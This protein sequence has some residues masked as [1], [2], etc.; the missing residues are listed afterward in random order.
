MNYNV[1][2]GSA[3]IE[4]AFI[5]PFYYIGNFF[6]KGIDTAFDKKLEKYRNRVTRATTAYDLLL[7]K[8]KDN[9]KS[10]FRST[11]SANG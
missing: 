4:A 5:I 7:E 3:T 1:K 11:I 6:E 9:D 10:D 8:E 2:K